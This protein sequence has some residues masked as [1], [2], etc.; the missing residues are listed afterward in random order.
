MRIIR[1]IPINLSTNERIGA[2]MGILYNLA[3]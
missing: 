2:E 3:K 1:S